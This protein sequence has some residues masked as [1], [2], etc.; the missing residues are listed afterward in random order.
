M[1]PRKPMGSGHPARSRDSGLWRSGSSDSW[2]SGG[3]SRSDGLSWRK[4]LE[5]GKTKHFEGKKNKAEEVTS[6]LKEKPREEIRS[7]AAKTVLF[8]KDSNEQM[9]GGDVKEARVNS[10]MQEMVV[11][12]DEK[13]KEDSKNKKGGKFKR[14]RRDVLKSKEEKGHRSILKKREGGVAGMEVEVQGGGKK[15]KQG[16]SEV[17][18]MMSDAIVVGLSEQP[19]ESK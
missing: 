7:S 15:P 13:E 17:E 3:R 14:V 4:D 18:G 1:P 19:C 5:K 16:G 9:G 12:Q 10:S 6:P 2:S 8:A 11:A